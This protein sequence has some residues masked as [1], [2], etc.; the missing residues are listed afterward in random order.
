[1]T[2]ASVTKALRLYNTSV[3]TVMYI[4]NTAGGMDVTV[5][6]ALLKMTKLKSFSRFK[7]RF[8]VYTIPR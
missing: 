6:T 4:S 1:M 3:F 8:A 7:N 2:L 5:E